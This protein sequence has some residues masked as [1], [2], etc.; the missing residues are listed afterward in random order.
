MN[1]QPD[2]LQHAAQEDLRRFRLLVEQAPFCVHEIDLEGYVTS[3]NPKGCALLGFGSSSEVEG[4]AFPELVTEKSLPSALDA[5]QR[6]LRG[7]SVE[8]ECTLRNPSGEV[9]TNSHLFPLIDPQGKVTSLFGLSIDVSKGSEALEDLRRSE[10]RYRQM[11]ETNLAV[12]LIIDPKTGTIVEAN[13]AAAI[14]YGY[15]QEE[16]AG[17]SMFDINMLTPEE[18]KGE[19]A[20]AAQEERLVFEFRHRLKD[21]EIRDVEVLSGPVDTPDGVR[22]YSIIVDITDR[23]Q[24]ERELESTRERYELAVQGSNDGIW[25]VDLVKGVHFWSDR[26]KAL[27]GYR[28]EDLDE[29]VGNEYGI[30]HPD[31]R[32][33]VREAYR[34]HLHS[35]EPYDLEV[36]FRHADGHYRWFRTRGQAI[37]DEEGNPLRMSGSVRDIHERHEF[38]ERLAISEQR[39]ASAVAGTKEGL[40]DL[41]LITE[42]TWWSPRFKELL[43]YQDEEI[44][45]SREKLYAMMHPDDVQSTRACA[46]KHL[47]NGQP[48]EVRYRLMTKSGEYRWF[49]ARGQAL[50]DDQ[51][52]TIRASGAV[53]DVHDEVLAAQVEAARLERLSKQQQ[54]ILGLASDPTLDQAGLRAGCK[55]ITEIVC[56]VVDAGRCSIMVMNEDG[57]GL[58]SVDLFV[59][60][61]K[62]HFEGLVLE[63]EKL[64]NFFAELRRSRAIVSRDPS[65]DER[66]QEFPRD[67]LQDRMVKSSLQ[68]PVRRRGKLVGLVGIS[69]V[70]EHRDWE[71]DEVHFALD[72]AQQ[73]A[74][75]M[76]QVD[77]RQVEQRQRDL[78]RQMLQAQKMESL[79]LMAGGVAHDFNNLLVAILGNADL[80]RDLVAEN[81]KEANLVH[82]IGAASRRAADLCQQMLAFSG[83][84]RLSRTCFDLQELVREMSQLLRVTV[85]KDAILD[86]VEGEGQSTMEGDATQV[87]QVLLNL[88]LNASE[89]LAGGV[90]KITIRTG[91]EHCTPSMV[92]FGH[93]IPEA[94]D[95]LTL[96]V[97]DE[98]IGMG[99]ETLRKLFDPFFST[100]FTGRG[101]GLASVLG[102]VRA[103]RGG[104]EVESSPGQGTR[105]L[106]RFPATVR[107]AEPLPADP[108]PQQEWQGGGLALLVD[109]DETVLQLGKEML[110]RLGFR[111]LAVQDGQEA[112]DLYRQRHEE[113]GLVVLDL[114]MPGISGSEVYA[115]LQKLDA[116]VPVIMSSGYTEQDVLDRL[117]SRGLRGFLQKPYTLDQLK[118]TV[119]DL[120]GR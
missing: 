15:A 48:F 73:V 66:F 75:L 20:R 64:P 39:L 81:P 88:I 57:S 10:Q 80:L 96:E 5:F 78:E 55:R 86:H 118:T 102:I 40:W 6:A 87:R 24:V 119:L 93:P 63:G 34:R 4:R 105:F 45:A 26:C 23:K 95:Y 116:T 41:D 18:I 98:G 112:I 50:I 9:P 90:G 27:L 115:T 107:P 7:E 101:L 44:S 67:Y 32:E 54:C 47:K 74:R 46:E 29:N 43:G 28:P 60:A 58:R 92:E 30:M 21:G 111:V 109:D 103:H 117:G 61:K 91:A 42:R 11:F 120:Q 69:E 36:R 113:L 13:H 3:I 16:L 77:A 89:S 114:T 83:H 8:F 79:G 84:G 49:H 110:A 106:A 100:K 99:A 72:V 33:R 2:L 51:G 97:L 85:S 38:S 35:R 68:V 52:Q 53:A 94:G 104:I 70:R 65:Q 22:L 37:W 108:A 31:D 12:K 17:M 25:D 1:P 56:E 62:A 59:P 19:M 71:E 76:E 82:E 14:F